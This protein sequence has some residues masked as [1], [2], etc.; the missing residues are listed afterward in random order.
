M[1]K[2]IALVLVLCMALS[3][4]ACGGKTKEKEKVVRIGVFEPTSGSFATPG[5]KEILGMQYA[6]SE[7]PTVEIKGETYRIELVPA[8]NGSSP[9]Q[10]AAAAADL[11]DKNVSIVLGSYGSELSLAGSPGFEEAGIA[12]I[13]ASCTDPGIT[14]GNSHY[15]RICYLEDFQADVLASFALNKLRAGTAYCLGEL[16]NEYDQRMIEVFTRVFA[17][18]GG[19]VITD[20]FPSYSAEFKPYLEKA[21]EAEAEVLFIPVSLIYATQIITQAET[22]E[23]QLPILGPD[24][25]DNNV[26][27]NAVKDSELRLYVSAFYQEGGNAR[28]DEG[29]KDFINNNA[30]AKTANGGN[31]TV[32]AVTAMGYDAYY[33]ALEAMKVAGS[34]DKADILAKLPI[35]TYKGVSGEIAFDSQG[36]I[37]RDTAFIKTADNEVGVWK[38]ETVQVGSGS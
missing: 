7:T 15:F 8:D 2:I 28:F 34:V 1:K 10:A 23:F 17:A 18:A 31:D 35:V 30:E 5:K 12:C 25:L 37:L 38:L 29:L 3:L 13:G 33:L 36:D 19:Q 26:V 32:A 20:F 21:M 11:V 4:C 16:G 14:A 24:G 6:H 9:D 22:L 27:L